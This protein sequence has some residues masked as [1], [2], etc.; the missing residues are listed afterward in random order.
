MEKE[1]SGAINQTLSADADALLSVTD[2]YLS[3]ADQRKV[4]EAFEVARREHGP[5][6][7]H[8][9]EL[10]VTHPLTVATYLSEYRLDADALAAALLHDI[11]EDT[12]VTIG[13]IEEM[14]GPDVAKLV[15]G[16][17]KLKEVT[18]GVA[19]ERQMSGQELQQ[20]T[21]QRLFQAMT[22]DVRTVIIKIFDRLHNM[23]TIDALPPEKQ[24]AKSKETLSVF[25]PLANRLGM[26]DVKSELE[27]LS[28]EVLKPDAYW[29]IKAELETLQREQ[30][31][32][33]EVVSAQI[34]ESLLGAN[35]DVRDVRMAPEN[36]Y[37]VYQDLNKKGSSYRDV[38]R[39]MRLTV[40]LGDTMSCYTALGL[41]HQL[42]PAVPNSFDDYIS[43]RRDNLYQ[44][45]HTRVI[46]TNGQ[47]IKIRLRTEDME[48]VA[49]IG[50]LA[51]WAYAGTPLWSKGVADRLDMFFDS[52]NESIN[53]ERQNPSAGVRGVVEDVLRTQIR[54][55]TPQ[56]DPIDL[57]EG[58]TAIDFAYRIHTNLG[59]QCHAAYVNDLP[60][61]L[62]RPLR[63]G[64]TV[65][66]VSNARSQPQRAWL[67][68]DLGYIAT[69]Y[70]RMHARRWFRRLPEP[71]AIRQGKRLLEHEL[72]MLGLSYLDHHYIAGLFGY[73][74]VVEFYYHIGR[75]EI[76]LLPTALSTRILE[77]SWSYGPS[78]RLDNVV[79]SPDG[80]RFII[81]N[82][83]NRELRLCV[84]CNPRP[85]DPIVG[86]ARKDGRVT[87]HHEGCYT[88]N[89]SRQRPDV[90]QRRLK[91]GW[92][93]SDTRQARLVK[94]HVEVYDR[95]GL[96]HDITRLMQDRSINIP[97]IHTYESAR[98][99]EL[100]IELVVEL[101]GPRQMVRLLHQMEALVNVK[102]VRCIPQ[103]QDS[104][105]GRAPLPATLYRP[106]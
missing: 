23:R 90:L 11:A 79:Y 86:Y 100:L 94:L 93:E 52:I 96:L 77:D 53:V 7:R 40:L 42:W 75:A 50:V 45:L 95:P 9:G 20:A 65:R 68:E 85:R 80:S 12:L 35:L 71:Q 16:V 55:Y 98:P 105:N 38:D 21:F 82:A 26:W 8:S 54:V 99:D 46:H 63:S 25:A 47:T 6:T 69:T 60:Y 33:F 61:A 84:S 36:I 57:V 49:Q 106:E 87:V 34:W 22:E 41:L 17:T 30:A 81:T 31:A 39:M 64:N 66:I 2:T 29:A 70:A 56:G 83:D 62:N 51:K 58:A 5:Q 74:D 28:L 14:F 13:E 1:R 89:A 101:T 102:S 97:Q 18:E 73:D 43:V 88:L 19:S 76:E 32:Q 67:D 3:R 48:K 104:A 91:L 92:G 59:N 24:I 10:F 44:S 4:E 37:T 103:E 15:S 72:V 78:L 27:A